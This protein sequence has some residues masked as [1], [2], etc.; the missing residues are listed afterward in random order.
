MARVPYSP[1]SNV[2][3]DLQPTRPIFINT[4]L[5]AFGGDTAQ[6]TEG[7]GRTLDTAGNELA[8]RA[9]AMQEV[10]N[11]ATARAAAVNFSNDAGQLYAQFRTKQGADAGP[12][13]Y[14][15]Y[16]KQLGDIRTKYRDG[17]NPMAGN[18]YDAQSYSVL[19][20]TNLYA[21][22]HSAEQLDQY[23]KI[24]AAAQAESARN[25]AALNPE[26]ESA[27]KA[28]LAQSDQATEVKF[29][30]LGDA[31]MA[32]QKSI[33][34]SG[35]AVTRIRA[36]ADSP[37]GAVKADQLLAEAVKNGDVRGED[38]GKI[39]D[40][41]RSQLN[42]HQSRIIA[43][44]IYDG[45]SQQLG[46]GAVPIERAREA[47]AA[48]ETGGQPG[49]GYGVVGVT[50]TNK[51]GQTGAPLGRYGIM[52]YNLAPWLAKAGMAP[53]SQAEFLANH[54]A[55][56][57]L[58]DKIFGDDMAKN[59]SFNAAAG[60]WLGH[61]TD[62]LG[63]TTAAYVARANAALGGKTPLTEKVAAGRAQAELLAPDDTD[64]P[65]VVEQRIRNLDYEQ[66]RVAR[67]NDL[68]IKNA[69]DGAMMD[70]I[71]KG[72]MTL[73]SM[74]QNPDFSNAY[75][76][77]DSAH[78]LQVVKQINAMQKQD[79]VESDER[80]T[81]LNRLTGQAYVDPEGFKKVDLINENLTAQQ[82]S[83]LY[84]QQRDL[85][86]GKA[87]VDPMLGAALKDPDVT[88]Q[89]DAAGID[90]KNDPDDYKQFVG[91]LSNE[92]RDARASGKVV[93]PEQYNDMTAR[94]LQG[95]SSPGKFWQI[96]GPGWSGGG[97]ASKFS[98]P[99]ENIPPAF[100][101]KLRQDLTSKLGRDPTNAEIE[102]LWALSL[103]ND[104]NL[105]AKNNAR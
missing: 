89:L 59:G 50:S 17:L 70:Q 39:R 29:R 10:H 30:G 53:M 65:D 38:I 8:Q 95:M 68:E 5:A 61:G 104:S 72:P 84:G 24:T 31:D 62:S 80:T 56:D 98:V 51:A 9:M 75:K 55:Q 32:M 43:H 46:V 58:F 6:A 76:Q 54:D 81:N 93:T 82:R 99:M 27:Y 102:H 100:Q 21:A 69:L 101:D 52:S 35:V 86:K 92:L 105:R 97:G 91:A 34:R 25:A 47:I 71:G 7:L 45:T 22:A 36:M 73:T 44:G 16:Q 41:V 3:P 60:N 78:Q 77:L 40:Y 66:T 42:E 4:P 23:N 87:L 64:L 63:T 18:L 11:E 49:Q 1:V 14:A 90:K 37:G 26:D 83:V 33:A 94:L 85:V 74:M 2:A 57:Q 28:A 79:N 88:S 67:Q 48:N 12:A 103:W 15:D 20:R 19:E 96:F 13:A